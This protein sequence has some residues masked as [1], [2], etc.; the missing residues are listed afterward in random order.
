[1]TTIEEVTITCPSCDHTWKQ[2]IHPSI[3]SWLNPELIT[4]L[5]EN[6]LAVQCPECEL[7]IRVAGKILINGPK[8]MFFL[9]IGQS[10]ERIRA[11][12]VNHEVVD[13]E[14]NT[15]TDRPSRNHEPVDESLYV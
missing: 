14:G 6:G 8:G 7:P 13:T 12:L 2:I 15:I 4:D 5:Y 10:V 11:M 1:M 9:D 3:C